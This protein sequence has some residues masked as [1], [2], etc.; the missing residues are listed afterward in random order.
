MEKRRQMEEKEREEQLRLLKEQNQE[1]SRKKD[2]V[3][4]ACGIRNQF[5]CKLFSI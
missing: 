4:S 2:R 5:V 1:L 3:L